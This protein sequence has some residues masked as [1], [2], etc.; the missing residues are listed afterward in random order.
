MSCL[1]LRSVTSLRKR[2]GEAPLVLTIGNFDGMH[3]GHRAL[4]KQVRDR[5]EAISGSKRVLIT[6]SP[7][8]RQYFAHLSGR[9]LQADEGVLTSVRIKLEQAELEKFDA[10]VVL[11]FSQRLALLSPEQF[12][13][14]Q[15]S[16]SGSV[17]AVVIGQDWRFG[18]ERAGSADTIRTFALR[19]GFLLD[20]L[21]D[22]RES[23]E[24]ISSSR[25]RKL[26]AAGDVAEAQS[27]LGR[28]YALTDH[29]RHGDHRGRT[30]GFPTANLWFHDELLPAFGVYVTRTVVGGETIRSITNVGKRP[31]VKSLGGADRTIVET[32]LLDGFGREIYGRRI[33]VEFLERVRPELRFGSLEELKAQ[34][35]KDIA[36]AASRG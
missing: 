30:I 9:K 24:R 2:L 11:P 20:V 33:K 34:I 29:V 12:L 14:Q 27:L 15:V 25:I 6:F 16:G 23:G 3:C 19:K 36:K 10:L 31:T 7:H 17:A 1:L 32:H 13:E 35:E 21:S 26:L 22:Q 8:P 4:F 28:P 5:S 18:K